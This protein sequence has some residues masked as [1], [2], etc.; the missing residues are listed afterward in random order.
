MKSEALG[1]MTEPTMRP[2]ALEAATAETRSEQEDNKPRPKGV[3]IGNRP[4]T[5][6]C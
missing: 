2:S 5:E 1:A 4:T 3:S 6:H